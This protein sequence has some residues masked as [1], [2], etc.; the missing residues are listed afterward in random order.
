MNS[1]RGSPGAR[2]NRR[3]SA[4]R[5]LLAGTRLPD[6]FP[7]ATRALRMQFAASQRSPERELAHYREP[8]H[9]A[10]AWW[11]TDSTSDLEPGMMEKTD[12]ASAGEMTRKVYAPVTRD[13]VESLAA[14]G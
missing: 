9:Q 1:A 5:T 6:R 8:K 4:A 2:P 7:G 11:R 13:I 12:G 14:T 3:S 10:S